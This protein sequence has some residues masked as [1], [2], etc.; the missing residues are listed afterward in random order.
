MNLLELFRLAEAWAA[1][2]GA[3]HHAPTI[4]QLFFPLINFL[5]FVFLIKRFVVPLI[6]GHLKSR[7]EEILTAVREAEEGKKRAE[8]TI[9]DYQERLAGINK[10]VQEIRESLRAEG[11][12]EK[13]KML[14]EAEGMSSKIREDAQFLSEQE[15]KLAQ[16]KVR[17]EMAE[18]AQAT[19][20]ELLRR[21]LSS[22]DQGR[23]VDDFL[24]GIGQGR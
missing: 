5:I 22:A 16:Q 4:S 17:E 20:T 11:E 6:Q 1:T 3:E 15:V 9:Q 12:R 13:T 2:S 14:S 18:K 10:E 19:A 24:E 23:L 8:A 7:R 21:H